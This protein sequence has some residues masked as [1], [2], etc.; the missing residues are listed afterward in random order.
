MPSGNV[1]FRQELSKFKVGKGSIQFPLSQPMPFEL[2]KQMVVFRVEE[3]E[4]GAKK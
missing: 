1:A 2:I 3:V 4:N